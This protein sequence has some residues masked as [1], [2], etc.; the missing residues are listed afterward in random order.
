MKKIKTI[1]FDLGGVLINYSIEATIEKFKQ[2]GCMNASAFINP[3]KQ[4]GVLLQLERGEIRP[5]DFHNAIIRDIGHAVDPHAIDDALCSFL[6]DIPEYKLDMLLDLRSQG[7][8]VFML[9]NTNR[10][11]MHFMMEHRFRQQG[12]TVDAYFDRL[13]LSYR[14]KLVKPYPEIY[15]K[16]IEES[17]I[18]PEESLFIDD[19]EA[20]I[21]TARS[22][23]FGTYLAAQHEDFRPLFLQYEP[24][25]KK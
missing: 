22:L 16:M 10:I 24:F 9:S 8:Q 12:L 2:I 3:Y 19:S 6:L 21:E 25:T 15:R 4:S 23:G 18:L 7:Y 13:F 14:M 17:G 1:I 5:E 20:N 11:M